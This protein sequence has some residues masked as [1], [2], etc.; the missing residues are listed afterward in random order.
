MPKG[1]PR[2][3]VGPPRGIARAQITDR[4][5]GS[6]PQESNLRK[7]EVSAQ[8]RASKAGKGPATQQKTRRCFV[9]VT[10]KWN[11]SANGKS[12]AAEAGHK[13]AQPSPIALQG[14]S[15]AASW[16]AIKQALGQCILGPSVLR[17]SRLLLR[18]GAL[19]QHETHR[20]SL[21]NAPFLSRC[22]LWRL[23]ELGRGLGGLL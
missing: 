2:G 4:G 3:D 15:S 9:R 8:P 17:G 11:N 7:S 10:R 16:S 18:V 23:L 6:I 5:Q 20:S 1:V 21:C 13:K 19:S 22:S 14:M 12:R